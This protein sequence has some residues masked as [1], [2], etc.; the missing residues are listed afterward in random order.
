MSIVNSLEILCFS[1]YLIFRVLSFL[2]MMFL[3]FKYVDPYRKQ[4]RKKPSRFFNPINWASFFWLLLILG[5]NMFVFDLG[6]DMLNQAI[7]AGDKDLWFNDMIL[8]ANLALSV[9]CV[10]FT[11]IGLFVIYEIPIKVVEFILI[12]P[13]IIMRHAA[14]LVDRWISKK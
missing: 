7:E 1:V 5:L 3:V 11:H 8:P 12:V 10:L 4:E 13:F 9:F 6:A 2:I 14:I